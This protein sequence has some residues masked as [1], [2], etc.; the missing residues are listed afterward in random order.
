[1]NEGWSWGIFFL[2]FFYY[3]AT[4]IS[5]TAGYHRLFAHKTYDT[6][7]LIKL[8]FLLFG[9][10][11]FQN[12]ALKW[13]SDHRVH[14][15]EVDKDAD[16]YN[17][18]RGFFYAHMGW[19]LFNDPTVHNIPPAL[20]LSKDPLVR[21]QHKYYLIICSV[22]GIFLPWGIGALMGYPLGG[23]GVAALLRIV[24][25][26][27]ATFFINSLCHFV[28]KENYT[29]QNSAKDSYLMAFFTFG[30]GYHNFHHR[31]QTDFRNG[32]RWYHFDPAKW[33]ISVL[34]WFGLAFKIRRVSDI[35]IIRARMEMQEKATAL[36]L[37]TAQVDPKWRQEYM[38][39]KEV[40]AQKMKESEARFQTYREI[41]DQKWDQKV[42]DLKGKREER[43]AQL[44]YY[45]SRYKDSV[46]ELKDVYR[47]AQ[48]ITKIFAVSRV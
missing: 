4:G 15:R 48:L 47:E 46:R 27:H 22:M 43:K 29:D 5:I 18:N 42:S 9:A 23:L 38:R 19:I 6:H 16:P 12:S 21:W 45:R 44:R 28:G 20:D 1:M 32:H 11:T 40:W 36:E 3:W 17:I 10:A 33:L 30:E 24:I 8:F 31:F 13:C 25:V 14:H 7:P 35:A 34:K 37:Q 2:T 39:L 26:H 41:M